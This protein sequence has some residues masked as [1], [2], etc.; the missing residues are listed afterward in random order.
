MSYYDFT[1]NFRYLGTCSS[2]EC[3]Y[4]TPQVTDMLKAIAYTNPPVKNTHF[5]I[6]KKSMES[7]DSQL[8]TQIYHITNLIWFTT[9]TFRTVK[10]YTLCVDT[11]CIQNIQSFMVDILSNT[12]STLR[13]WSTDGQ[14]KVWLAHPTSGWTWKLWGTHSE[15]FDFVERVV[16]ISSICYLIFS[17]MYDLAYIQ[18]V[19]CQFFNC[20][21]E[22]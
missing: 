11:S 6:K 20:V 5:K 13:T 15:V 7:P 17:L 19:L 12:T 1:M 21:D 18:V 8:N 10:C 9:Q 16:L 4:H 22:H 3:R 2:M 14:L